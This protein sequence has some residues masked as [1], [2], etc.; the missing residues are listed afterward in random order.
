M[1]RYWLTTHWPSEKRNNQPRRHLYLR[2]E[3]SAVG[4]EVR[5]GDFVLMFE[6][7]TCRAQVEKGAPSRSTSKVSKVKGARG[8]VSLGKVAT[9]FR[10]IDVPPDRVLHF[11]GKEYRWEWVAQ[12]REEEAGFVP[13]TEV[14]R[15]LKFKKGSRMRGFGIRHSG[16]GELSAEQF[17]ELAEI[18]RRTE[19]PAEFR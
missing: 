13:F 16:L 10:K 8:I 4:T 9:E 15:V 2:S 7:R 14:N 17:N 5:P 18:F 6:L 3:H 11:D 1:A 12:T 19:L